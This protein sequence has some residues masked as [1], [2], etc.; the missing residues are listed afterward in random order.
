MWGGESRC[1]YRRR[2]R[3]TYREISGLRL[4]VNESRLA[5]SQTGWNARWTNNPG[6]AKSK[7]SCGWDN[8]NECENW[9]F[10]FAWGRSFP[11]LLSDR[12]TRGSRGSRTEGRTLSGSRI[13]NHGRHTPPSHSLISYL[14]F[15]FSSF[16]LFFI[17][18]KRL[19]WYH[20]RYPRGSK[21]QRR[22]LSGS[23]YHMCNCSNNS[24]RFS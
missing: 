14:F 1:S 21:P 22:W 18:L 12:D 17:M 15:Y 24:D 4:C 5:V 11:D 13:A 2:F 16:L 20:G 8:N 7:S 23:G 10:S 9:L 3:D 6:R 19:M